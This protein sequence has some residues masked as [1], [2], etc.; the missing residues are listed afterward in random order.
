MNTKAIIK[1]HVWQLTAAIMAAVW[2]EKSPGANRAMFNLLRRRK[3]QDPL[4]LLR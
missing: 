2:P 1:V 3:S 4:T